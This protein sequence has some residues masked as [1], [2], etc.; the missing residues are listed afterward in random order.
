M[1]VVFFSVARSIMASRLLPRSRDDHSS[2]GVKGGVSRP[3][4][5]A[6]AP[7][8][9]EYC[10]QRSRAGPGQMPIKRERI[11]HVD[12]PPAVGKRLV[13]AREAKGLSQRDLAFPG[14]S[15]AYISRLERGDPVSSLQVRR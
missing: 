14:C 15:A 13:E 9:G 10:C 3:R 1:G 11:P 7:R 12:D 2:P 8:K 4:K 6:P 5:P